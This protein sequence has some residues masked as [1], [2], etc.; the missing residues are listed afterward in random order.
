MS[1]NL[2]AAETRLAHQF[3]S[4]TEFCERFGVRDESALCKAR[5]LDCGGNTKRSELKHRTMRIM[6]GV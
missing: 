4:Y 5:K 2:S 3:G 1:N 6:A